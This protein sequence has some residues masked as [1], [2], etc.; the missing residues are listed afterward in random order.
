M[1]ASI[2]GVGIDLVQISRMRRAITRWADRF[3]ER[4]LSSNER[5]YC[6]A[7][8]DAAPH[9]AAR[10]AA[11]EAGLKALG[12]GW[13]GVRWTDLEVV[14]APSGQPSLRLFGRPAQRMAELGGQALLVS[15]T[16]DGDYAAAHVVISRAEPQP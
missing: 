12:L 2:I 7:R 9:I 16:H 14:N 1:S 13:R 10:F 11:K 3:L 15:L 5:A 8:R 4:I 6:Q